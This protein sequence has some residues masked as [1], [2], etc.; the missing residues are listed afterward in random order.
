MR[1]KIYYGESYKAYD[2]R[3]LHFNLAN[4][5]SARSDVVISNKL[6]GAPLINASIFMVPPHT[7][8]NKKK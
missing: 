6:R 7:L 8:L 3:N 5:S 2:R 1:K 4:G